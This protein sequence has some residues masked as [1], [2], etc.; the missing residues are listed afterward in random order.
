MI[1]TALSDLARRGINDPALAEAGRLPNNSGT[2]SNRRRQQT[3]TA[4]WV[5]LYGC[6]SIPFLQHFSSAV[7]N[8]LGHDTAQKIIEVLASLSQYL[9]L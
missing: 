7:G 4:L 2:R 9:K 5:S 3:T 6:I 8:D 1:E